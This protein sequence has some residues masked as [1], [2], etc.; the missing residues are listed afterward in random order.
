MIGISVWFGISVHFEDSYSYW[1]GAYG[2]Y[3]R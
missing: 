1:R 2:V 3:M